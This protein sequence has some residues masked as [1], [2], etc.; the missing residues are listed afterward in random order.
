MTASVEYR[1][2]RR[3]AAAFRIREFPRKKPRR[4]EAAG[5]D[6]V[7]EAPPRGTEDAASLGDVS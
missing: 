5:S 6:E 1:R 4:T 2:N 3:V 7:A